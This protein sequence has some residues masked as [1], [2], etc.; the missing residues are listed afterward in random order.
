M[1]SINQEPTIWVPGL[2]GLESAVSV[3]QCVGCGWGVEAGA[4]GLRLLVYSILFWFWGR[5][6]VFQGCGICGLCFL[7]LRGR[8][9]KH[10]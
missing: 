5:F 2:L 8:F 7:E 9:L 1:R 3:R 4:L 10:W 6:R